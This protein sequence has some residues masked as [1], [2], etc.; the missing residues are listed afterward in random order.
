MVVC[1]V[2]SRDRGSTNVDRRIAI[3]VDNNDLGAYKLGYSISTR[4]GNDLLQALD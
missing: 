4:R 3:L 2:H 1:R